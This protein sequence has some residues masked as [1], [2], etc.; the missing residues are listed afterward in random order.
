MK[1]ILFFPLFLLCHCAIRVLCSALSALLMTVIYDTVFWQFAWPVWNFL[2]LLPFVFS[3]FATCAL[4]EKTG[5]RKALLAF[6]VVVFMA[7]AA[8]AVYCFLIGE[9]FTIHVYG[10]I[11]ALVLLW[12]KK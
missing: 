2:L 6:A 3:Y 12:N 11:Y 8:M 4:E 10:G 9:D 7:S 1:N 5:T